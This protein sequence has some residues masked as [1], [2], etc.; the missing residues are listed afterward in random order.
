M[1]DG[2]LGIFDAR[3]IHG[4]FHAKPAFAVVHEG[5]FLGQVTVLDNTRTALHALTSMLFQRL[6]D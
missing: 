3:R 2:L 6:Q 1:H 5:F 4:V